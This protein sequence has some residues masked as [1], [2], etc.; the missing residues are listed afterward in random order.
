MWLCSV[1]SKSAINELSYFYYL[2][3]KKGKE[4]KNHFPGSFYF[5]VYVN[6]G[7]VISNNLPT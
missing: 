3:N 2:K 6:H 4:E 7:I 1:F 5:S